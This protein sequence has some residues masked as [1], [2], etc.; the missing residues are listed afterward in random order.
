MPT[1]REKFAVADIA[2]NFTEGN[3]IQ[4]GVGATL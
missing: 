2:I 1:S 4:T 3:F